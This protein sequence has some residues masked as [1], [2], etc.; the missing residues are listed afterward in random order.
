MGK[1]RISLCLPADDLTNVFLPQNSSPSSMDITMV[2]P[3]QLAP[4]VGTNL[5]G[6]DGLGLAESG[7]RRRRR[8]WERHKVP[9][10]TSPRWRIA[11]SC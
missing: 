9:K 6:D 4:T 1:L 8:I 2:T 5:R 11:T 3:H 10:F 7:A